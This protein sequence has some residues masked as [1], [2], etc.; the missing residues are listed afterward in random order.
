[1]LSIARSTFLLLLLGHLLTGSLLAQPG[2][3]AAP[4]VVAPVIE[5]EVA[6][7]TSFVAN[8]NPNRRAVIGSAVDGRVIEYLVNAGQPVVEGEP[9][10]KL[11]TGTIEIELAGAQAQLEL[12]PAELRELQN[13]SRPEEIKLAEANAQAAIAA[14]QYA[15]AKLKRI[16]RLFNAAA[17]VSDDEFDAAQSS[18]LEASA[19]SSGMEQALQLARIGTRAEQIDQAKARVA[20]QEQVV[21]GL[22]DRIKKYTIRSPFT[23]SVAAESTEAGAWV[24]QGDAVAEV[25]EIEPIEVEVYVPESQI[26]FIQRGQTC[27]ILVEAHPNEIFQGTID[28]IVPLGDSRSRTFPVRV[29]V[30]N[31]A[32]ETGHRL[33]PGMLA[34]AMLPTGISSKQL[35]VPKD[36]L[37]LGGSPSIY[38][39]I[40]QK[41]EVVPVQIGVALGSWVAVQSTGATQLK[42]GDFVITRGNE[43]LRPGQPVAIT[44]E[45]APPKL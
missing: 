37:R 41:A 30:D 27:N 33:M 38:R 34:R 15:Q 11:L 36:A 39:V 12:N 6:S 10:A 22:E 3:G 5:R 40:D 28:R 2:G 17:G 18:A 45:Q 24:R 35:L 16:E 8:I 21:A 29:L 9:L 25:V 4:V 31:P 26:R 32:T 20:V 43:R 19:R 14:N 13:G 42:L 44:E 7:E 1:M 23:G